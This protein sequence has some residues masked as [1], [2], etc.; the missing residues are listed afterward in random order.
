MFY[1]TLVSS[2]CHSLTSRIM[3]LGKSL[4][5]ANIL[6]FMALRVLKQVGFS[7]N[8]STYYNIRS[9]AALADLNEFA[10]LIITLKEAGFVFKY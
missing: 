6:C 2:I 5:T 4:R 8:H 10:G 7:L 1:P 3:T 9:R